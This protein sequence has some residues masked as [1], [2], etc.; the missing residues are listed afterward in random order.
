[1]ASANP[2]SED[3][4]VQF[5]SFGV[6][7]GRVD[8]SDQEGRPSQRGP[9]LRAR[10]VSV[11]R[12]IKQRGHM[13]AVNFKNSLS[14]H[15]PQGRNDVD[16]WTKLL[17]GVIY[18]LFI[19]LGLAAFSLGI[20]ERGTLNTMKLEEPLFMYD[21]LESLEHAS[22]ITISASVLFAIAGLLGC[23]GTLARNSFILT[24]HYIVLVLTFVPVIYHGF[25]REAAFG[26][27]EWQE[28]SSTMRLKLTHELTTDYGVD[29]VCGPPGTLC[30]TERWDRIQTSR[31]CCGI[32]PLDGAVYLSTVWYQ[33]N[34]QVINS[35]ESSPSAVSAPRVPL[36]CCVVA[37]GGGY[38]NQARCQ[39]S[40]T[41][42]AW[43]GAR[44]LNGCDVMQGAALRDM[45]LRLAVLSLLL[46]LIALLLLILT[47]VR[48]I[49]DAHARR[50]RAT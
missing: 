45:Q 26:L 7:E 17:L 11:C 41:K 40:T 10:A 21:A 49:P 16:S 36:S 2:E 19:V 37:Q 15:M 50:A 24:L 42:D 12:G 20:L 18:A 31:G 8:T 46:T 1:M 5:E 32:N 13:V 22:M 14:S 35:T 38:V 43:R 30:T 39:T 29:K 28:K 6:S 47:L 33:N 25:G 27:P 3:R 44:H 34:T 23:W 9:G 4:A 48:N